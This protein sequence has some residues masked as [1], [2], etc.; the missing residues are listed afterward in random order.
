MK[1]INEKIYDAVT[2]TKMAL[3]D[4]IWENALEKISDV[5]DIEQYI[6]GT[7]RAIGEGQQEGRRRLQI[8]FVAVVWAGSWDLSGGSLRFSMPSDRDAC[9]AYRDADRAL[10]TGRAIRLAVYPRGSQWIDDPEWVNINRK[11]AV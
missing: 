1:N 2:A 6:W 10:R 7:F 9:E 3:G 11:E 5:A 8:A 4:A